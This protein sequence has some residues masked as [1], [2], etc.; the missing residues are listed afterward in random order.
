M[1]IFPFRIVFRASPDRAYDQFGLAGA[2]RVSPIP[3][4]VFVSPRAA[5]GET[6]M[7]RSKATMSCLTRRKWL[8]WARR[9]AVAAGLGGEIAPATVRAPAA[10]TGGSFT[11]RGGVAT[12][13]DCR[14][15]GSGFDEARPVSRAMPGPADMCRAVGCGV[16][17]AG[18][19]EAR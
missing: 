2:P 3:A 9:F 17:R 19:C 11:E 12:S 14:P 16:D 1:V 10:E 4:I 13:R 15:L 5:H 8:S 6:G 7:E 18:R